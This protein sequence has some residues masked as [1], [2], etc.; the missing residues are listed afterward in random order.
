MESSPACWSAFGEVP[1]AEYAA[2]DLMPV[3]RLS[4]DACAVQHPGGASRRA[5]QSVG[6]PL[7]RLYVQLEHPRPPREMNEVMRSFATRK[8][9][10]QRL[11]PPPRFSITVADV[12]PFAGVT[13]HAE[14]VR[15]WALAAWHDWRAAHECIRRWATGG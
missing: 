8:A 2:P 1:A 6:L 7:A 14:K 13:Q 3:H 9:S 10:L 12:A 4:V 5:I 11:T 15:A